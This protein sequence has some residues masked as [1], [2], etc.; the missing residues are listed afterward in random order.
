MASGRDEERIGWSAIVLAFVLAV[1]CA[2]LL[3][4][5]ARAFRRPEAHATTAADATPEQL[6]DGWHASRRHQAPRWWQRDPP[7]PPPPHVDTPQAPPDLPDPQLARSLETT[8]GLDGGVGF[9]RFTGSGRVTSVSG[10]SPVPVGVECDVRV[11]P[12]VAGGFNCLVRVIC[13]GQLLYPNPDQSAGYVA[14]E[15]V[16]ESARHAEDSMPTQSDTDPMVTF[17]ATQRRVLVADWGEGV[18]SFSAQIS[19]EP[20]VIFIDRVTHASAWPVVE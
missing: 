15:V 18:R 4:A 2:G 6:D 11:L 12:V 19:L 14:C 3:Y 16:G 1:L 20:E 10:D 8:G 9:T 5:A 17:D 7:P 13:G